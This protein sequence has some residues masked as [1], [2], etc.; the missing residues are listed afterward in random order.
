MEALTKEIKPIALEINQFENRHTKN[1][2]LTF[3]LFQPT[4]IPIWVTHSDKFQPRSIQKD[5]TVSSE[6]DTRIQR[7]WV[8]ILR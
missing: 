6:F 7:S 3:L 4:F 2:I 1:K 5:V 8:G